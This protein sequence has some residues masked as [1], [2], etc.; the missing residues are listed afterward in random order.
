MNSLNLD[1]IIT[2]LL[3]GRHG[4]LEGPR[5]FMSYQDWFQVGLLYNEQN[6]I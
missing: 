4:C 1:K 2:A 3:L 6:C 5:V